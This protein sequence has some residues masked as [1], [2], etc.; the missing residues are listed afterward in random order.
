[1]LRCAKHQK[2]RKG[3]EVLCVCALN[4][5]FEN[6]NFVFGSTERN[7]DYAGACDFRAEKSLPIV[8]PTTFVK[9]LR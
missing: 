5:N 9:S 6:K 3:R 7:S 2:I 8:R 4:P 1:M